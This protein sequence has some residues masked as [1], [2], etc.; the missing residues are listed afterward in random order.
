MA[1]LE[2]HQERDYSVFIKSAQLWDTGTRTHLSWSWQIKHVH[3]L[4]IM[5]DIVLE[6]AY[7]L[8]GGSV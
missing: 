6:R 7:E 1:N 8:E 5:Q 4:L 2:Y 3:V